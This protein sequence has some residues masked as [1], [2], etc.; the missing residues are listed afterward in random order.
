[1][2]EWSSATVREAGVSSPG[3]SNT[4]ELAMNAQSLGALTRLTLRAGSPVDVELQKETA[5]RRAVLTFKSKAIDPARERLDYKD[6]LV[7][8]VSFD[9][10]GGVRAVDGQHS[11][12]RS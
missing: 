4:I 6:A 10:A 8:S 2:P 11:G 5:Q 7:Q 1:M 3:E 9:D 12:G